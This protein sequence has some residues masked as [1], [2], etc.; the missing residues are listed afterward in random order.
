[1]PTALPAKD[2]LLGLDGERKAEAVARFMHGLMLEDTADADKAEDEYLKALNLDP[3]N[4]DLSVK[5]AWDDLRRGDTPGAINL[6]KDTIKAA[7]KQSQPYI[8]LSYLYFSNLNKPDLA[9]KYVQQA[10]DIDGNNIL[11]YEYLKE[12]YKA[13]NQAAKI[14]ALLERAAKS[15]SKDANYWMH[16][17]ALNIEAYLGDDPAKIS[18]DSLKKIT[19]IFQKALATG[20]DDV[21]VVNKVADFY[22]A[23]KQV[24]EAIPL[25]LRVIELDPSQNAARENLARCYRDTGD[26]DKA[27]ETLEALIKINPVQ[28]RAYEVLAKIYEDAGQFDKALANYEQSVLVSPGD[29]NG[30]ESVALLLLERF[31]QPEK[32][33]PVLLDARRRF[34]DRPGFTYLLALAYEESKQHSQALATFEQTEVGG[35][36]RPAVAV[37]QP[38]L[39]PIRHERGAGRSLRQGGDVDEEIARPGRQPAVDRPDV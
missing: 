37:E 7:P 35:A 34:P 4:A 3:G 25:Y 26:N 5:V 21:D 23:T 28:P 12:I 27:A 20:S 19:P 11:A 17:G 33:V 13:T 38:V 29:I 16:L 39:F 14:P 36:E 32:A 8:A 6:L 31:K 24:K 9:Q 10:L 1:M 2:L 15:D 30:Y 18:D 22:V